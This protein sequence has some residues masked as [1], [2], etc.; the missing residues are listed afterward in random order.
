MNTTSS[1]PP[2]ALGKN[3]ERLDADKLEGEHANANDYQYF[4]DYDKQVWGEEG[5]VAHLVTGCLDERL[6]E[7]TAKFFR[8]VHGD[9]KNRGSIV[10][11]GA[12]MNRER[13]SDGTLGFTKEVPPAIIQKMREEN[14]FT[15]F[16]GWFDKSHVG[17]RFDYCRETGWS[18]EDP[19]VLE[20]ARP[21]VQAVDDVYRKCLHEHWQRQREFMDKVLPDF[22]FNNSVFSTVTVNRNFRTTYHRDKY[23]FR[24][25][26]GNLVVLEGGEDRAGA[27]VLPRYR[28]AF[29]PRPTDVLLMNVHELH[30]NL[31]IEGKERLTAVLYAR[32]HL[33]ECELYKA[34]NEDFPET[35]R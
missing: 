34:T 31:P 32:E 23:D 22:K 33:D 8:T 11:P 6:V 7:D 28:V 16:L 26:M 18:L 15:D 12:M 14:T 27:I 5:L 29:A 19:E 17:D 1:N 3:A 35:L 2:L 24:G 9:A 25:G 10:G 21:F 13:A 20:A 30:G 4:F